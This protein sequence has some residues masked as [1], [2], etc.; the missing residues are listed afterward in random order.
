MTGGDVVYDPHAYYF[1]LVGDKCHASDQIFDLR[2]LSDISGMTDKIS[3][4]LSMTIAMFA[5]VWL[6]LEIRGA[7]LIKICRELAMPRRRLVMLRQ[8]QETTR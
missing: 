2:D 8:I 1:G 5:A 6:I 3:R 7:G 4:V